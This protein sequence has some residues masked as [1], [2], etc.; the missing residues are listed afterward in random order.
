MADRFDVVASNERK[1]DGFALVTGKPVFVADLD[2]A[3]TLHVALL[4]D[5]PHRA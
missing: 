4:A 1:V 5:T 3:D 2:M